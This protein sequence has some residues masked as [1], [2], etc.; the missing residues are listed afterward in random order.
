MKKTRSTSDFEVAFVSFCQKHALLS[1]N[2]ILVAFSGGADSAVLLTLLQKECLA[3]NIRLA[4]FHVNHMIRGNESDR[5]ATFCRAF[6]N[7]RNIPFAY[8]NINIPSLANAQKK[9]LEETARIERYRLLSEFAQKEGFAQI[10]TAHNATDHFETILFHLV[11]GM[12][13]HGAGGIHP[14]RGN[15]IRPLLSFTKEEIL[16]YAEQKGIPYVTDSTNYNT[17]YTRNHIRHNI[18][19]LLY[20]INPHAEEAILRFSESARQDDA[21]LFRLAQEH[22]QTESTAVLSSLDNAILSRVLLIKA[23]ALANTEIGEKHICKLI[24]KIRKAA[25]NNFCG[26]ISLPCHITAT[27]TPQT[28]CLTTKP[29]SKIP[30]ANSNDVIML[31]PGQEVRFLDRYCVRFDDA[32]YPT[33]HERPDHLVAYIAKDALCGTPFLRCRAKGDRYVASGMTRNIKK[34]LC[35]AKIPLEKRA[36]LPILCDD[37]GILFVPYLPISDRARPQPNTPCYRLEINEL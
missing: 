6:C 12:S 37:S 9:G 28:F 15:I 31:T 27:I 1:S 2:S 18:L 11:R 33:K 21:F 36:S 17:D 19:P 16:A 34:M 25:Q 23:G 7:E 24:D 5:D 13:V 35:D 26:S 8:Q 20:S 22:S 32:F 14:L 4:A 29:I 10:A 3:R 30:F